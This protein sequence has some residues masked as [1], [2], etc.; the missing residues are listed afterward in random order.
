MNLEDSNCTEAVLHAMLVPCLLTLD[1]KIELESLGVG[2]CLQP[3]LIEVVA[4][5]SE[6]EVMQLVALAA[7]CLS[8]ADAASIVAA[9]SQRCALVTDDRRLKAVASQVAPTLTTFSSVDLVRC[10]RGTYLGSME[11][12]EIIWG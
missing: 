9:L 7:W 1:A 3:P 10:W 8:N 11:E 12:T 2:A 5:Q 6:I 4:V